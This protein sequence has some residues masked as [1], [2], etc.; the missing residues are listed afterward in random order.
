MSKRPSN[1]AIPRARRLGPYR[2]LLPRTGRMLTE[3]LV[4]ASDELM[5]RIRD[6]PCLRQVA[7]VATL[8]GIVGRSLGMPDIHWGYGFPIGGVAAFDPEHGVVSREGSATTSTAESGC[9]PR[10]CSESSSHLGSTSCST[11]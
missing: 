8:P 1:Q 2:W 4:F 10:A 6:D 5:E 11:P 7:N 9:W 3:G